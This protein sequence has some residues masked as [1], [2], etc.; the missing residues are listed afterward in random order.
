MIY[1]LNNLL[2]RK[3]ETFFSVAKENLFR[4][5]ASQFRLINKVDD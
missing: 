5:F 3:M 2:Q 1:F 4:F